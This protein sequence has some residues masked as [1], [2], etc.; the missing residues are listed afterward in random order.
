MALFEY[1]GYLQSGKR[2]SGIQ[3][4]DSLRSLRG[5]LKKE[6]IFLSK[7]VSVNVEA[8]A[9]KGAGAGG[10]LRL[11][12]EPITPSVKKSDIAVATRQLSTL[13]KAGVPLVEALSAMTEQLEQ[14]QLKK[15]LSEVKQL[16]NEGRSLAY[17][18]RQ[19]AN[20]FGE[21]YIS[22]VAAG[23]QSGALDS[24]LA[25]LADYTENQT[26]MRQKIT[27]ALWYPAIMFLFGGGVLVVILTFVLP[28]VMKVFDDMQSTLPL[29][30]RFLIASSTLLKEWWWLLLPALAGL[31]VVVVRYFQT[32]RGK[33]K[34]DRFMLKLPLVGS[35]VTMVSIARFC[36]TMATL[37]K[38]GVSLMNG[39]QIVKGTISNVHIAAVVDD[40]RDAI[41]EGED[42]ATPLRKSG[43]FPPMVYRMIAIGERSGSLEEML[44][45]VANSY[46]SQVDI[47]VGALT[48]LLEPVI[49]AVMGSVIGFVALAIIVPILRLNSML[50]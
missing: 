5:Q 41:Q 20:V 31:V 9:R 32:E 40:A 46:E 22:M 8:A 24:V 39:L 43:I 12:R 2:V 45:S 4:A 14:R 25:R 49:I 26:K 37:L 44:E 19:Y 42:I 15:I 3:E 48:S 27:G 21:L 13:L 36:R 30:T 16:V 1:Q 6:R 11:T 33:P 28:K 29:S 17:G 50:R 7:A 35:I 38:S 23:E 10:W 34:L 47:R 18:L